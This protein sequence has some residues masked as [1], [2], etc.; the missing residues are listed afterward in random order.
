MTGGVTSEHETRGGDTVGCHRYRRVLVCCWPGDFLAIS[1]YTAKLDPGVKEPG[2]FWK[3]PSLGAGLFTRKR[4]KRN[5]RAR[6]PPWR[7]MRP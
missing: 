1:S 6:L 4:M 3:Q 2:R 5:V 7:N